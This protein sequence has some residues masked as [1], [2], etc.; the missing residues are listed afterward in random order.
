MVF[1]IK[2]F[3]FFSGGLQAKILIPYF[4]F[5]HYLPWLH[6][7]NPQLLN[8]LSHVGSNLPSPW[9]FPGVHKTVFVPVEVWSLVGEHR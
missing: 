6:P 9:S 8:E 7:I 5:I 4:H 3:N 1:G 2:F